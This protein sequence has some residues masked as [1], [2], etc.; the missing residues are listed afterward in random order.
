GAVQ[1]LH[2]VTQRRGARLHVLEPPARRMAITTGGDRPRDWLLAGE[3][4]SAVLLNAVADG[5]TVS[6]VQ[7]PAAH[8]AAR[9]AGSLPAGAG[10]PA[11]VVGVATPARLGT[12]RGVGS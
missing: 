4:L 7:F 6:A 3:A 5:L 12:P 10:A 1:A 2:A 8:E 9:A 11:A